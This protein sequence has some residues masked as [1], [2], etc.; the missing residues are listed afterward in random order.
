MKPLLTSSLVR[1]GPS[2]GSAL[3]LSLR[4]FLCAR[5]T[6][7][8]AVMLLAV[9]LTASTST[10]A[11]DLADRLQILLNLSCLRSAQIGMK[12]TRVH[13]GQVLFERGSSVGLRPASTLKLLTAA[14]ALHE[15]GPE[16]TFKT[17]F[18]SD[19][20]LRDGVLEGN[21]IVQ[22]GGA[23]DL[24]AERLW[25]AARALSRLGLREVRGDLVADETYFDRERRPPGWRSPK[26]RRA[27]NAPIGPLSFNFNVLTIEV[28]PGETPGATARAS[29]APLVA[30]Q[31]LVNHATTSSSRS[32]LKFE[33]RWKGGREQWI[34][35][36]RIRKSSAPIRL[37]RSVRD[38]G[39]YALGALRDLLAREGITV[40]GN[41][42]SAAAP[43]GARALFVLESQPL[44]QVLVLMNKMSN[45]MVAE[46]ILKTLG[47]EDTGMAGTTEDGLRVVH[48]FLEEIGVDTT[49]VILADGSGLSTK[50]L[51][52]AGALVQ[53][54]E[55]IPRRFSVWPEFLSSL[56]I[57]GADGTLH[58][59]MEGLAE[60]RV[61]AKTGR[62]SGTV[63]L[64]GYVEN[65][66]GELLAF[67][68][69]VNRIRC[70]YPRVTEQVDRLALALANSRT[71][72]V[73]ELSSGTPS[74][75]GSP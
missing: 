40:Q 20:P 12:V 35:G 68:I 57:G 55:E 63:T 58:K 8:R 65:K 52:P 75:T 36:G 71:A 45:N 29:L 10:P 49:E 54:L 66:D 74:P 21:L 5:N 34:L 43:E 70:G 48:R 64:A 69:L 23:P 53:I 67:A 60:R 62:I 18:L 17:R 72:D 24:V 2:P 33:A 4:N 50:N 56:P 15:L 1:Y 46:T 22:G 6:W 19:A 25:Y 3:R 51:L 59:R 13:D 28:T 61:R 26:V 44:S 37:H 9:W 7:R 39:L 11:S 16:F 14:T 30:G 31:E 42:R 41:L 73:T 47:A 32:H 27:Y 38:P